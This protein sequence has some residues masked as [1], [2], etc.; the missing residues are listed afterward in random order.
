M[1]KTLSIKNLAIIEELTIDFESG[2]NIITGETGAGKSIIMG[3]LN[4]VFGDR[5]SSDDIRSGFDEAMIETS[6]V[7]KKNSP[8]NSFLDESA[9]EKINDSLF[10][11]RII[12]KVGKSKCFINSSPIPVSKLKQ[13]GDNLVDIHSQH[14]H[15]WLLDVENHI[16]ALDRYGHYEELL[17]KVSQSY[18]KYISLKQELEKLK[19]SESDKER[20]KD[21]LQYQINEIKNADLNDGEDEKLKEERNILLNT[22]LLMDATSR[23][24]N[25]L[26]E[27]SIYGKSVIELLD[28]VKDELD[29]IEKV[30]KKFSKYYEEM[31]GIVYQLNEI[32]TDIMR[33]RDSIEFNQNKLNFIEER[34][35]L[36]NKLKKKYGGNIEGIQCSLEKFK[37]EYDEI[38]HCEE[39]IKELEK[40]LEEEH[41]TLSVYC[42]ELTKV[43]TTV[44]S[45]LEKKIQTELEELNM[46]KTKFKIQI[47]QIKSDDGIE[48]DSEKYKVTE[49]GGDNVEFLISPNV[50]EELKPLKKI[51]SGGELSRIML[52]LKTILAK[53]DMIPCMIFDE[54]D[55]GIG[56]ETSKK[57]G[58]KLRQLSKTHQ[59]ICITHLPQIASNGDC[60][61]SVEKKVSKNRTIT[62]VR[63]LNYEERVEE[64][65]KLISGKKIDEI[66]KKYAIQLLK[67]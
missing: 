17:E 65:A 60:H 47:K 36:I 28:E 15:Q 38:E 43:R 11:K 32:S 62:S 53:V 29:K 24:Y 55:I 5:S 25:I 57:V 30:D 3:A 44:A 2:L 39:K 31:Q 34:L 23:L 61:F 59:I 66:S 40:E 42:K 64:I 18:Y 21:L 7:V 49:R 6:F 37:K 56:G 54:I 41:K 20:L 4:L 50:G 8:I 52:A 46:P 22:Q 35:E 33:Y 45:E 9:I 51:A 27:G 26:D 12:S 16:L 19:R 1:L 10:V 63:K 48:I 67:K 58:E 14:Q 13:F